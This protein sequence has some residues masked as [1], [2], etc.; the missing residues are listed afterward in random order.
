MSKECTKC[1][2]KFSSGSCPKCRSYTY[3]REASGTSTGSTYNYEPYTPSSDYNYAS[4]DSS[5]DSSSSGGDG[6]CGSGD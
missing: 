3:V 2:V 6:G 1:R 4:G 5:S